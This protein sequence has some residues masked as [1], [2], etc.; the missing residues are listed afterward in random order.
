METIKKPDNAPSNLWDRYQ[1][2]IRCAKDL[3]WHLKSFDEWCR[4]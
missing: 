3:G 1:I 2:Y 4:S